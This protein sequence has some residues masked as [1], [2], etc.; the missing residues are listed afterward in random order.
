ML[1]NISVFMWYGAVA[2]WASFRVNNVIPLYRLI[3]LGVL[4]LLFRRLPM[5]LAFRHQL[6]EIDDWQQAAF[7]GFFGPI[8]VSAVFYLY[9]SIDFLN[10]I[11]VDGEVREDAA[12]LQEIMRV[13]VWFL[14]ISSIVV[15]GLSVPLGKLGYHMPRT[16]SQALSTERDEHISPEI[17]RPQDSTSFLRR[18]R[19]NQN[20]GRPAPPTPVTF[21][22]G[23]R[24]QDGLDEPS[25]PVKIIEGPIEGS[26]ALPPQVP[27]DIEARADGH[28]APLGH[29]TELDR[30]AQK[31]E[32]KQK[33]GGS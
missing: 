2:P 27:N 4:I 20:V 33:Q 26:A 17:R 25:R 6:K 15:H 14:A 31:G 11:L 30:D 16:L 7:V 21:T 29:L 3:L 18:R 19:S 23:Q 32:H 5:V 13:V 12:R 10:Q 22:L 1:L 24:G 28:N 9:I 8:G